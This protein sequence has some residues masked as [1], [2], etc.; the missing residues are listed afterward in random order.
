MQDEEIVDGND[1]GGGLVVL[2]VDEAPRS[3]RAANLLEQDSR[4]GTLV[5]NAVPRWQF[6]SNRPA[7]SFSIRAAPFKGE[8][9]PIRR[10]LTSDHT[11][12]IRRHVCYDG[13]FS[14]PIKTP[15]GGRSGCRSQLQDLLAAAAE[16]DTDCN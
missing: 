5:L 9:D 3:R 8:L 13:S 11:D 7:D 14:R 16:P 10:R 4:A 6:T 15:A 12:T 2:A 1:N